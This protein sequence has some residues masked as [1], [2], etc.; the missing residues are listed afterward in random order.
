MTNVS[1]ESMVYSV[2]RSSVYACPRNWV[3]I[4]RPVVYLAQT[5]NALCAG[6]KRMH[7]SHF[8]TKA[9]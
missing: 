6:V 3:V 7:Y 5:A 9:F 8:K 4:G 2:M 1:C